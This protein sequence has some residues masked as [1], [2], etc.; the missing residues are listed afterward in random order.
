MTRH[1]AIINHLHIVTTSLLLLLAIPSY[2]APTWHN[3]GPGGGG[4]VPSIVVSPVNSKMIYAGCD[5]GGFYRSTDAGV[6]W[7]IYNTGLHD[8]YVEVIVPHP[9]NPN[10]I[11]IGTQ[12]GVHKSTDGGK[13]WIWLRNGFPSPQMYSFSAPIGVLTIDPQ[14]PNILYAGIGRPRWNDGGKGAIY[15]T[16][17]SGAHWKLVNP[18]GA[19]MDSSAIISDLAVNPHSSKRI[20]AATDHGLYRSN[21]SGCT[22][23]HLDKGLPNTKARRIVLCSSHP[24]TMYVSFECPPGQQPRQ[25]GVFRSDDGGNTWTPR[26]SGLGA[27][28][29]Q[30]NEPNEMTSN[31]DH[32]AVDPK[33]PNVVF[34]GDCSWVSAGIYR[35]NDGGVSWKIVT[36]SSSP[37]M[38]Y[39]W[40]TMWGP[41][42]MALAIDPRN[43]SNLYFSTSGHVFKTTD[44]GENWQAAYTRSVPKPAAAPDS[45]RG[46]WKTNG[47]EVTC[48]NQVVVHPRDPKRIYACYFDIGLLQSFDGGSSFTQ[49]VEGMVNR[50][51]TFTLAFDP[52]DPNVIYAGTGEWASNHG[53]ICKSTDGGFTW[54]VIGKPD[55]G[56][57][58]GQTRFIIV[59]PNSPQNARRIY[60]SVEGS[61]IYYSK[62]NGTTW[63]SCSNNLPNKGIRG[64]FQDPNDP[65]TL[66]TLISGPAN[67]GGG[68]YQSPDQ[69]KS[70]QRI[71]VD[72]HWSNA[73][74][75]A[76]SKSNPNRIYVSSREESI[77]GKPYPG[78]VF[79]SND[80]GATWQQVLKDKF[81]QSIAVNQNNADI[82]YAGGNDH[83]YHD[84]ALGSGVTYSNDGGK[85][86]QNLNTPPLTN[87]NITTLTIDPHLPSRIYAGTAGNGVFVLK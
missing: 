21:D 25:G 53:D 36:D 69:G 77:D 79:A 78:G 73:T 19:G 68:V 75:M 74:A 8:Y 67:T 59:D 48:L 14:H 1:K 37:K 60:V 45:P 40:I 9:S 85:I 47:M 4:W 82:V 61:G 35:S 24:E 22:W 70:W 2:A 33:N 72:F 84:E 7:K 46:W 3:I 6:T 16:E 27:R 29:G 31:I 18:G 66:L 51:N 76:V 86:W 41:S 43:P 56:L 87:R 12:G 39:G 83:P 54:Q 62:D 30:P 50:G 64:L 49:T 28:V 42:V 44:S 26:N 80:C 34:A 52:D 5:V 20:F 63:Q 58:D 57:P 10:V 17:D 13:S 38:K 32:L 65:N 11:Y 15:R 55:T 81:I 23:I 71:S